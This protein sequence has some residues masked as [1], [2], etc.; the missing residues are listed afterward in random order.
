MA[1]SKLP[2]AAL[3]WWLRGQN[4][5]TTSVNVHTGPHSSGEGYEI[6]AW[7]VADV[8]QP[9]EAEVE[10]I[11]LDYEASPAFDA[12]DFKPHVAILRVP[13]V[14][15]PERLLV[16]APYGFIVKSYLDTKNFTALKAFLTGLVTATI[17]I[18]ADYDNFNSILQ[19]QNVD[20]SDY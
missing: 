2:G 15:A 14:F 8:A 9:T 6:K 18:Q 16:L 20:L 5:W 7:V 3:E 19:E 13:Q 12:K 17:A 11:I 1:I 10:Q 4:K